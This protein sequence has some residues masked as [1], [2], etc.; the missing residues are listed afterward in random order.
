[1]F[2][3]L[4]KGDMV[5][6]SILLLWG[7]FLI[8]SGCALQFGTK[9]TRPAKINITGYERLLVM[10]IDKNFENPHREIVKAYG[11]DLEN[12]LIE[13]LFE[14]KNFHIIDKHNINLIL[15]E[16]SLNISNFYSQSGGARLGKLVQADAILFVD[17]ECYEK[18]TLV[19][20]QEVGDKLYLRAWRREAKVKGTFKVTDVERGIIAATKVLEAGRITHKEAPLYKEEKEIKWEEL[21]EEFEACLHE[22]VNKF[23]REITPSTVKRIVTLEKIDSPLFGKA[24]AFSQQNA[25][26]EAV[27]LFNKIIEE[28][29]QSTFTTPEILAQA[30]YNYGVA[31]EYSGEYEAAIENLK[32]A[33]RLNPKSLYIEEQKRCE[34]EKKYAEE[35]EKQRGV[36]F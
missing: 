16:Q 26:Q 18:R 21:D 8:C 27:P 1:M 2:S 3:I 7:A 13:R 6:K 29:K 11:E 23:I 25:W 28:L 36:S 4:E 10:S 15:E 20:N 5:R 34:Q 14:A 33:S 31:L 35:L 30:Y 12:L 19:K 24:A 32:A 9:V 22:I 17:L